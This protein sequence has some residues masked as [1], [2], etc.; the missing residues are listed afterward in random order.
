MHFILVQFAFWLRWAG[1]EAPWSL[2]LCPLKKKSSRKCNWHVIF[3]QTYVYCSCLV[4]HRGLV[5]EWCLT[6][7]EFRSSLSQCLTYY[8]NLTGSRLL[9]NTPLGMSV[10]EFHWALTEERRHTLNVGYSILRGGALGWIHLSL[11]SDCGC[12]STSSQTPA[13]SLL[14][15]PP[16]QPGQTMLKS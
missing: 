7:Q 6:E 14:S 9:G 16:L 12:N 1:D 13:Q 4:H 10:W 5:P 3:V 11:L 2:K 8:D 15:S